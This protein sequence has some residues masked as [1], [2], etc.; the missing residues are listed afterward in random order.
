MKLTRHKFG[1]GLG[2]FFAAVGVV[3][4]IAAIHEL[5]GN[6]PHGWE[7]FHEFGIVGPM[8]LLVGIGFCFEKRSS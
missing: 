5:V 3:F 7:H 6:R 8:L 4:I 2:L 1:L